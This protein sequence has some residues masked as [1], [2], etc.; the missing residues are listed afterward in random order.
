MNIKWKSFSALTKDELYALLNLRQQVFVVEQDCPF[1]DADFKDQDCDHL[2]AYQDNEL[3]GYLRVVKPGKQY[4]GPEIGRVLTAE[5]IRRE[6]A[7]KILT[8]EAIEFCATK[9]AGQEISISAQHRLQDFYR[10][11]GFIVQG[12]VY[13]EDD[14]DH[15]K[16]TLTPKKQM[17][18]R[19]LQWRFEIHPLL[20]LGGIIS[21]AIIGSSFIQKVDLTQLNWV[22]KI[23]ERAISKEKYETYLE[24]I[25]QSRKTGLIE[26]DPENILERMIDEELLIQ[27][28]IDLGMIENNPEIRS[29]IIQKMISSIVAETDNLR[30]STKDLKAFYSANQDLFTPS[31]KLHLIKLSFA[32]DQRASGITAKDFLADGDLAAAK[33]L[34]SIEV[35]SLPNTLL[36]AMKV[37]E[38]IGPYLTQ[39]ALG[40]QEGEVSDLIELDDQ[41]HLLVPVQKVIQ[42]A[43]EFNDIYQEVESEYIRFKGE[44]M[45]DEYLEDLRNWYDVLKANDL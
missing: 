28:G 43:P 6:G 3:V 35:I 30:I 18:N 27:R 25:A 44:E 10:D 42:G 23:D 12:E 8:Q 1:I 29:M 41:F 32:A 9:Y 39:V 36:P 40:L 4:H 11:F 31:P 33:S 22:A 24:S 13:L 17:S 34:A 2:L 37:R 15:I 7:G 45:L 26:S 5:K 38:Y 21:I 19:F 20:I 16:M 14:I